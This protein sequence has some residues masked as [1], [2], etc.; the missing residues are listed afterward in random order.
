MNGGCMTPDYFKF[1]GSVMRMTTD[2]AG[3]WKITIEIPESN[4]KEMLILSQLKG[5]ALE[6]VVKQSEELF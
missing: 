1:I 5:E 3:G 2:A 4:A 6:F